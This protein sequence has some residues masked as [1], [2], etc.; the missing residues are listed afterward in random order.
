MGL[1]AGDA[2]G[3]WGRLQ[4][5]EGGRDMIHT[6][7]TNGFD[8]FISPGSTSPAPVSQCWPLHCEAAQLS[9]VCAEDMGGT[10][11][12]QEHG[13]NVGCPRDMAEVGWGG[14]SQLWHDFE[15]HPLVPVSIPLSLYLSPCPAD[16]GAESGH[17]VSGGLIIARCRRKGEWCWPWVTLSPRGKA[18]AKVISL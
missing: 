14:G 5:M 18:R 2:Q 7:T 16:G 1:A 6:E 9:S 15:L 17:L 13:G 10:W 8:V 3:A 4:W 12:P 11:H